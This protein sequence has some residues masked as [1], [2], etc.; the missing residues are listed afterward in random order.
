MLLGVN[1]RGRFEGGAKMA[2]TPDL[3][4]GG[5]ERVGVRTTGAPRGERA[6]GATHEHHAD[7]NA[8]RLAAQERLSAANQTVATLQGEIAAKDSTIATLQGQ[9][10]GT[11]NRNARLSGLVHDAQ[12]CIGSM[13][14]SVVDAGNG[15]VGNGVE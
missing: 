5:S 10:R 15:L 2:S 12:D 3:G 13:A 4:A 1:D 14:Q 6:A 9:V 7:A 8:A 11:Q